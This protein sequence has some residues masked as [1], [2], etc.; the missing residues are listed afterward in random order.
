MQLLWLRS[1]CGV[2]AG[3]V[4]AER[5]QTEPQ[6]WRIRPTSCSPNSKSRVN[7]FLGS[8]STRFWAMLTAQVDKARRSRK[9]INPLKAPVEKLY[10]NLDV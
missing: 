3:V 6:I 4:A 10:V 8:Q 1:A 2:V 5:G 9:P 7:F